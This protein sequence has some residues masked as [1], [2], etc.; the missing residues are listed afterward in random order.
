MLLFKQCKAVY[1]NSM[2]NGSNI[3]NLDSENRVH[4]LNIVKDVQAVYGAMLPLSLMAISCQQAEKS[5]EFFQY[6]WPNFKSR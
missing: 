2:S 6:I 5:I 4:S 3:N 1:R